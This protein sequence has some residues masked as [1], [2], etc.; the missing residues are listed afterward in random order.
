MIRKNHAF[1]LEE[2]VRHSPTFARLAEQAA[3]SS[4]RLEAIQALIPEKLRPAVRPGP[5]DDATWCLV[6]E[7]STAAAKIRQLLP[8]FM[9]RLGDSGWQVNA[10]RVKVQTNP[11]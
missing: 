9:A 2:A 7:N 8:L 10:I 3:D 5:V 11:C 4:R 1:T 6:V